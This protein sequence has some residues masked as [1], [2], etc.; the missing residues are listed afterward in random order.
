MSRGADA[1]QAMFENWPAELPRKGILVTTFG[2]SI[3]FVSFLIANGLVMVERDRPDTSG[4]RKIMVS[5]DFI[6]AVKLE[7]ALDMASYLTM[8]F[9]ER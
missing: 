5:Y 4:A 9:R 3:P 8:G 1:W 6:T 2:E 7:S